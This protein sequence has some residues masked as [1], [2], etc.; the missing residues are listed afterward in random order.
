MAGKKLELGA[1]GETVAEN[2]TRLRTSAGL[3]YTQVSERLTIAGRPI[4]PVGVRRIEDGERRVDA[5]DLVALAAALGVSPITLLMPDCMGSDTV[6]VGSTQVPAVLL[7]SWL[8]A[9][10]PL[11]T[12]QTWTQFISVAWPRWVQ[13][14]F[15][16]E[17][18]EQL[19]KSLFNFGPGGDPHGDD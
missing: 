16:A 15:N 17:A 6:Q 13:A 19:Q 11:G 8:R 7:W 10:H 5:D 14:Q 9:E 3:S 18:Q 4:N 12:D 1:T 2:I